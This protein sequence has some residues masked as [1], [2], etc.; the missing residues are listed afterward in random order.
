MNIVELRRY[1]LKPGRREDLIELF[2]REFVESQEACG[3]TLLG[4]YR[5]LDDPQAFVWFRAFE[6]MERR[7]EALQAFY[8]RSDAWARNRDA[9]NDTM[10][11]SD[12]V[13]LLR[14]ARAHSGFH[15]NGSRG[16]FAPVSIAM[17]PQPPDE[18]YVDE[19]ERTVL[20]QLRAHAQNVAYFVTEPS[21][22]TYPRLPVREGEWAFVAAGECTT[23]DAMDAWHRI[24]RTPE[25]LRLEAISLAAHPPIGSIGERR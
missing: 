25:S 20:P 12:N 16:A 1:A 19:F 15:A 21:P 23:R 7:K 5:D 14:P 3:I 11:D 4:R 8:K 9:A 24:W 22:N 6:S 13:L 17:L 2:E 10:I 18:A